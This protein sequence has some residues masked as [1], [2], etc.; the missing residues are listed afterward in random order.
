M[1][2]YI[3]KK[4]K[5]KFFLKSSRACATPQKVPK[6]DVSGVMD[7]AKTN[8]DLGMPCYIQVEYSI[9]HNTKKK[10]FFFKN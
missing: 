3:V 5:L 4:T 8:K 2:I 9:F 10:I 7:T 1:C 6:L